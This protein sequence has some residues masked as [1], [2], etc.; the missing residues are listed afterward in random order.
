ML[1]NEEIENSS[2]IREGK[3]II[4]YF[5]SKIVISMD[6]IITNDFWNLSLTLMIRE[7]IEAL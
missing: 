6:I 4:V 2:N 7:D 3:T 5:H 1:E